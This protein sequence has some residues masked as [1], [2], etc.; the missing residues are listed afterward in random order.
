[1]KNHSLFGIRAFGC[2]CA[3]MMLCT[4]RAQNTYPAAPGSYSGCQV[5]KYTSTP[6]PKA[7]MQ[8]SSVPAGT[9]TTSSAGQGSVQSWVVRSATETNTMYAVKLTTSS[10]GEMSMCAYTPNRVLATLMP[11]KNYSTFVQ[12]MAAEGL[13]V[14]RELMRDR[15][16]NPVY[17]IEA[18]DTETDLVDQMTMS[19]ESTGSCSLI[20]PDHIYE[21]NT[22]PNDTNYSSQWALEKI[23]A[24]KA[25][26]TRTDASSVPVAVLDTGVNYNHYDINRNLWINNGE[27]LGDGIDNDGNGIVDDIYGVSCIGGNVSGNPMDDNGHGSHCAGIIGAAGNNR[28]W[29]AGVAWRASIM[30]LKFL[31]SEG[32][33]SASDAIT[34]LCYAESKNAKI[35]NCSFGVNQWDDY[36]YEQILKMSQKGILFACAAGNARNGE[37]PR[38]N[39]EY[40]F[41]PCNYPIETI[42]GVAASDTDDSL[43]NFSYY[44][45]QN[46]DIAA[47]GVNIYSTV[48]GTYG[49][50]YKDGTSMATPH[51]VGALALLMAHYPNET[52]S[53]IINRLYAAAEPVDALKGK[54]RT[55]ARLSMSGFF[56][57]SAPVEISVTQGTVA[58]AVVV[59]WTAVNNG[60]HYRVWRA[61]E[62]SGSKTLLCDWQQGLTFADETAE[63]ETTYWY[64]IQAASSADGA[65]SSTYSM[66]V[67]G[68]RPKVDASRFTVSFNAN[69]G[70][71]DVASKVYHTGE[72]YAEL[73][74]P[75]YSG[76]VFLGWFTSAEGGTRLDSESYVRSGVTMLY[77]HWIDETCLRVENLFARQRYPWNGLVDVTFNLFGVPADETASVSLEAKEENGGDTLTLRTFVGAAP[78]NL[79]N[80]AQHV[81]WNATADTQAILYTNMILM[82]TVKM[83]EKPLLPPANVTAGRDA[84]PDSVTVTW[85]TAVNATSYEIWRATVND[86]TSASLLE[87]I[88][89]T[90][91]ID[92]SAVPG[93]TYYYWVRAL[94]AKKTSDYSASTEGM[95]KKVVSEAVISG[96]SS[97]TTGESTSFTCTVTYNDGKSGDVT[98]IWSISSGLTYASINSAGVLTA[99]EV[100]TSASVTIEAS[101]TYNGTTKTAIKTVTVNTK[102]V[103]VSF[104]ANGGTV[105]PAT[106]SYTVY[107]MYSSLPTPTRIGY[108]FNGWYTAES[109]G[110]KVTE[111]S[112]VVGSITK[113]YAHW[114][115]IEPIWTIDEYGTLTS[116]DLNGITDVVIPDTVKKIGNDVFE[117]KPVSS[118]VIPDSVTNI[119]YNAFMRCNELTSVTIPGSVKTIDG[120]AFYQCENLSSVILS[121]GV[122][123]LNDLA[124]HGCISL[125]DVHIPASLKTM[126]WRNGVFGD[127]PNLSII[128]VSPDSTTFTIVDGVLFS[129]DLSTLYWYP[130][131]RNGIYSV[132]EGVLRI[133]GH[134]FAGCSKLTGIILPESLQ[135]IGDYSFYMCT[136]LSEINFPSR[137]LSIGGYSFMFC[138]SLERIEVPSMVEYIGSS[139]FGGCE[140]L[141]EVIYWGDVPT[142]YDIYWDSFSHTTPENLVSYVTSRWTGPTDEWEGCSVKFLTH[143]VSFDAN[144]GT[145]SPTTK[146]YT[147][148]GT[149]DS[150][151]TPT[152][153]G[154]TFDG[155][156]TA[157]SGGTKITASS[158]VSTSITTLYAQWTKSTYTVSFNSNGGTGTMENQDV[159]KGMPIIL[160]QCTFDKYGYIF[161]GWSTSLDNTVV[162][163]YDGESFTPTSDIS[164]YAVWAAESKY[165]IV[166]ISQG[167]EA[168]CYPKSTIDNIPSDGWT[169]E[170]KTTKLVLRK[171]PAGSFVMN[172]SYNITHSKAFYIGVFEITQKQYE[173]VMGTRPSSYVGDDRPVEHVTYDMIRGSVMG[174]EWPQST[175]VDSDSF[176]GKI[177]VK[178]KL[179]FDLPTEAQW[180]YSCRAGTTT[181]YNSGKNYVNSAEDSSMNEVGRY[182]YNQKDGKGGYNAYHTTVGMYQ[183]NGWGLYDMHGNVWEWC[184]DWYGDLTSDMT[185]P[186]GLVSGENRVLRGGGWYAEASSCTSAKRNSHASSYA[187]ISLG[188]RIAC[189]SCDLTSVKIQFDA[190]GGSVMPLYDIFTVDK[191]YGALPIPTRSGYTFNGWYTAAS[192]GT[193]ITASSTVSTS[194]TTLYA[195]WKI[196]THDKVQL[197]EN[198]PY[199]AT[200]NIGADKPEDYG[201]Y[202]WWGDTVGYK[203]E[204]QKWVASD[205][206]SSN[207]SFSSSNNTPTYYKDVSTL[208]SEGWITAES[209]LAPEHDAAHVHWGGDWRMPTYQEIID[210]NNNCDWT[211]T[212]QN[213]VN[214]YVVRGR[215]DYSANSIFLPGAGYGYGT[216]LTDAGSEGCY[217]SSVPRPGIYNAGRL[218]SNSGRHGTYDGNRYYGQSV[219]PLQTPTVTV[220]ITFD[221]NGGT[222]SMTAKSVTM[223]IGSSV[224]LPK[225]TFTKSGY[226]FAGWATSSNGS[227]AY[228]DGV[229]ITPTTNVVLYAQWISNAKYMVIDLS[230]GTS[231]SKYPVSYLNDVPSGGWTETYKTTKLVMR[232]IESGTF[233]MGSPTS[234]LGR[235]TYWNDMVEKRHQVTISKPFY[236]GVFEVTQRQ[237]EL[238]MGVRP[239]H[240]KNNNYYKPRPVENVS[241]A[242]VRGDDSVYNWPSSSSVDSTSF[243]GKLRSKTGI[244]SFDL[245]T[246]AQWEYACRAG[247]TTSLNSGKNIASIDSYDANLMQVARCSWNCYNAS[248][249]GYGPSA[250]SASGT[251]VVGSYL[252]NTWGLYDMHGNVEEM[253]LDWEGSYPDV[254]V[255]DPVGPSSGSDRVSRGGHL[256]TFNRD[257]RSAYRGSLGDCGGGVNYIGFRISCLK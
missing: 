118:V 231:A 251:A 188:F 238:V 31:N 72:K 137:L 54:V 27:I 151:P 11:G 193:K 10:S 182:T 1:M 203:W 229:S 25:W 19:I 207:F 38:D 81:I 162:K 160:N 139:A 12:E 202:F 226:V 34:C 113:L 100:A 130:I 157:A 43:A 56:G 129:K 180:E 82:A 154:Y 134:V 254:S 14:V 102:S 159:A 246:E 57:I 115:L 114:K 62:E 112:T 222:G 235:Y 70:Q 169:D 89:A 211:W 26:E 136:G 155:W 200:A 85:G 111:D 7:R 133:G 135:S 20:R 128:S 92:G 67:S 189:T 78:T 156:Y 131:M 53:D 187:G 47:P 95:R 230:G 190:N 248:A 55:G 206:S 86:I 44:G 255:V 68:F 150:L 103:T 127:C 253:C 224:T 197:W 37:A 123:V 59:Y 144:G 61:S 165:I 116:V 194:I 108:T 48:L 23:D 74:V 174:A 109:G 181:H 199:W 132:P 36:L 8:T 105:S 195:Q 233:M 179:N 28:Q 138:S 99:F 97:V 126:S 6:L 185:D 73:P 16:G 122:E 191:E 217:W 90:S 148:Y 216:S 96:P 18:E 101:Y 239:S 192:G 98:P 32:K 41:Y 205:G 225:C 240:Y 141:K 107:G 83:D 50:D 244:L 164:L 146:S 176:M 22:V 119:A 30:A 104:D 91:F 52:S 63:P 220:T 42:V 84:S 223:T 218:F 117:S 15:N 249:G 208:Q 257:C 161:L 227:V 167:S 124:F 183:P 228:G 40:P 5:L 76:K 94:N 3:V 184:L 9:V 158:T 173:L 145:V 196:V 236:I 245:P 210:L 17:I 204:N 4:A 153:S 250:T 143:T 39:D 71:M 252:P 177:R 79:V 121:E 120:F 163:Y 88:S 147:V 237:Y 243:L 214:G 198:G 212:T 209:V 93:V 58:D 2:F 21:A 175:N 234:E 64:Y 241:R 256:L 77:A 149:Y 166:D 242:N 87:T 110:T 142:S 80:G 24:P 152:R 106:K 65:S 221:A 178:T 168:A 51:V 140:N 232:R 46:V 215:G 69:G 35:I 33:G 171:I 45:A 60:T 186:K 49:L 201:Y 75:E 172:D 219:R 66:G 170:Y 125:T 13:K 213:G 29:I 247:T